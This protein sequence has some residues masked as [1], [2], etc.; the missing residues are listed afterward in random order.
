MTPKQRVL[1]HFKKASTG[2]IRK[3][4]GCYELIAVYAVPWQLGAKLGEGKTP[5]EAWAD[6]ARRLK[7]RK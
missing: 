5:K 7:E 6:A 1:R 3:Y 4:T 2:R